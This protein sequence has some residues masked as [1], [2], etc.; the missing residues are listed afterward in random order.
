MF[1]NQSSIEQT[2]VLSPLNNASKFSIKEFLQKFYQ[3]RSFIPIWSRLVKKS[4]MENFIFCVVYPAIF[5][6]LMTDLIPWYRIPLLV[7]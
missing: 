1:R 2:N 7:I 3:I 6:V 4:L 5:G